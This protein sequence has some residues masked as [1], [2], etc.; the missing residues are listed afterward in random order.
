[1]AAAGLRRVAVGESRALLPPNGAAAPLHRASL[2]ECHFGLAAVG[3]LAAAQWDSFPLR[4]A[5]GRA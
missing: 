4:G 3:V 1:M 2:L 5:S